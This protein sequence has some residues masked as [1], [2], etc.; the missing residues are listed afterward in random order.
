MSSFKSTFNNKMDTILNAIGINNRELRTKILTELDKY[1]I[2][3]KIKIIDNVNDA[4]Q[5]LENADKQLKRTIDS[6]LNKPIFTANVE[7]M[8]E[9]LA[10]LQ[11]LIILKKINENDCD[12]V[13]N[14]LIGAI[15]NKLAVVNDLLKTN[16]SEQTGGSLDELK[17][18]SKYL[19]Y[20]SKY[21]NLIKNYMY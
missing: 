14:S 12:G 15:T 8:K 7:R 13:I 5:K 6:Q 18:K 19:K 2:E 9:E 17:Y 16:L 4:I 10:E 11:G 20:K 3:N 1:T 21:L